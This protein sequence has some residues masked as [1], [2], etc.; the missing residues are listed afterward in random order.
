M[1]RPTIQRL[2][3]VE[4]EVALSEGVRAALA[5][6]VREIR[7]TDA[8]VAATELIASFRPDLVIL[9]VALAGGGTAF[10]VLSALREL[11][12]TPVVVG[13]SGSAGGDDAFRLGQMGVRAFLAKPFTAEALDATV[14]R[15]LTSTPDLTPFLRTSV[16]RRPLRELEQEVRRTMIAEALARAQGSRRKAS[17]LL[18][19]SRQ[20][21][22]HILRAEG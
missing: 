8:A 4:D 5:G 10:E 21:L 22:Q 11:W 9:D 3:V 16:G 15:A 18:A 19:I 7:W 17:G 20:L 14:D 12:P 2:L 13:I 6:R 1:P